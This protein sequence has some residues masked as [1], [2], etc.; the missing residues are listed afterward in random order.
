MSLKV[1]IN[2][3]F[4]NFEEGVYT[5]EQIMRRYDPS[6]TSATHILYEITEDIEP[7]NERCYFPHKAYVPNQHKLYLSADD[8]FG[9]Y[10]FLV[11]PWDTDDITEYL[12]Q[13]AV[14]DAT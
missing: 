10:R 6:A 8:G 5:K 3:K 4:I 9:E 11:V 1:Q 13:L 7:N 12:D 14:S 2:G